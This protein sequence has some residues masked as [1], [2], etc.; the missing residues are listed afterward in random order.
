MTADELKALDRQLQANEGRKS[1]LYDDATGKRIK[2]GSTVI[3]HPTIGLGFNLDAL[4]MPDAVI[5]LWFQIVRDQRIH[6]VSTAL[7]WTMGL[8]TGPLRAV[9]DIGYNSGIDGLLGF[10]KMLA[11]LQLGDYV[12]ASKEVVNSTLAPGRAKRLAALILS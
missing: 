7:P 11:A 6:E 5:D 4:D 1:Y 3:G 2:K 8:P 9:I 10:H 12:T